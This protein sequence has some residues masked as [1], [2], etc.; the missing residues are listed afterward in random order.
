MGYRAALLNFTKGCISPELEARFDLPA[1]QAGLRVADNVVIR[2]TG[3]VQKRMGTR[4]VAQAMG[5]SSRLIPFQFS[6]EQAYA[7]EF[8]QALMRPLALGGAVLETGLKVTDITKEA[9]A[10]VTIAYHGYEV[11]DQVYFASTNSANFGMTEILDRFLIVTEVV[12]D[13]NFRV[14]IN[15]TSF[16]DFGVDTGTVRV[17]PPDA[18]PAPPVVPAPITPPAPPP[19]SSGGS[20]GYSNDGSEIIWDQPGAERF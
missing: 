6:D 2:R 5:T 20:G 9:E 11:G 10:K 16:S 8:A 19:V 14:N 17:A 3:G 4:F 13:D 7:L 18:P 12:D 1:Y 15:S